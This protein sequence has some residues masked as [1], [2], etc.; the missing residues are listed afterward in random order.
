MGR[1]KGK[2]RKRSKGWHRRGEHQRHER[3]TK[4]WPVVDGV[5]YDGAPRALPGPGSRRKP[6]A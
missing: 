4:R 3:A 2:K 1:Q 6:P 5:A